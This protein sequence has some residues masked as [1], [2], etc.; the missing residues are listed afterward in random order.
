MEGSNMMEDFK[1]KV[2]GFSDTLPL[3]KQLYPKRQTYKQSSL[4]DDILAS[5]LYKPVTWDE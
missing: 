3:F 2:S 1:V 5:V 4:A